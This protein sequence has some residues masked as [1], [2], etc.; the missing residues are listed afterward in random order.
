M[1]CQQGFSL[2]ELM[3][4]LLLGS[5]VLSM[6]IES[7]LLSKRQAQ[8]LQAQI[9]RSYDVYWIYA[10]MHHSILQAGFTPCT[11]LNRL[12]V[13]DN[14][15]VKS[16]RGFFAIDTGV[17]EGLQVRRMHE[18]FAVIEQVVNTRQIR[19]TQDADWVVNQPVLIADCVHAEIHT[20]TGIRNEGKTR[21]LSFA[22]PIAYTY[23][24]PAY[25]GAW[26][27]EQFYV[28]KNAQGRR[29]L[30]YENQHADVLSEEAEALSVHFLKTDPILLVQVA[31]TFKDTTRIVLETAVRA[32]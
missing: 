11:A 24:L 13:R 9:T 21:V 5:L 20:L 25:A 8:R 22:R 6:V 3:I 23:A 12:M 32:A 26:V 14:R 29:A 28:K 10:L 17:H 7:Y 18:R 15:T 16:S 2:V 4:A 30:F 31:L 19:V 27:D 1:K